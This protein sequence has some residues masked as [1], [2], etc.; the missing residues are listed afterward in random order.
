M[1][2]TAIGSATTSWPATVKVPRSGCS[3][4]ATMRMK[5]VLPAPFGPRMATGSTGR[6]GEGQIR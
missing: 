1:R 2:R 5:V 3:S 4:V 6:Q